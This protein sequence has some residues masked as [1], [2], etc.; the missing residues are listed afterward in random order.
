ME[1][2]KNN[3]IWPSYPRVLSEAFVDEDKELLALLQSGLEEKLHLHIRIVEFINEKP[4]IIGSF[5][6][7]SKYRMV[8]LT[9]KSLDD[10]FEDETIRTARDY[11][12]NNYSDAR[13]YI[14]YLG[15]TSF[16]YG[17]RVCGRLIAVC[18]A[19][20]FRASISAEKIKSSIQTS[21]YSGE[22][23]EEL[24]SVINTFPQF[25]DN[26]FNKM[27]VE[28]RNAVD[29]M[30][31]MATRSYR[32]RKEDSEA[33]FL[34][35]QGSFIS[36]YPAPRT[37]EELKKRVKEVLT[38]I[39]DYIGSEYVA[40]FSAREGSDIDLSL[41]AQYGLSED[42]EGNVHFNW[43]R[44]E[45][46][47]DDN[48]LDANDETRIPPRSILIKGI[49]GVKASYFD[50]AIFLQPYQF[51]DGHR[52]IMVIGPFSRDVD[53]G[54]EKGFL[55][56]TCLFVGWRTLGMVV[57]RSLEDK[58]RRRDSNI[59][60]AA[61]G[62]RSGLHSIL[63][64][65]DEIEQRTKTH[66]KTAEDEERIEQAI[67]MITSQIQTLSAQTTLIMR[68]PKETLTEIHKTELDLEKTSLAV[69]LQNCIQKYR[70]MASKIRN[71]Q[72]RVDPSIDLLPEVRVD[73]I[74]LDL[75]FSNLIDNALKYSFPGKE[76][77]IRA[78]TIN[79]SVQIYIQNYGYP[80]KPNERQK[81]FLKGYR[82]T[83]HREDQRIL[84]VGLG[85]PQSQKLIELHN[86]KIDLNCE[87]INPNDNGAVVT[88]IVT[89]PLSP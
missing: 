57:L 82:S 39:E 33:F 47:D 1:K 36:N 14:S 5:N 60:L 15:L 71:I 85:L 75:A 25:N 7:L 56:K 30:S 35:E 81:I 79:S 76:I 46:P 61:H 78:E 80:I 66:F 12:S 55:Q 20:K 54:I 53:L 27:L 77:R 11:I 83:F 43:K 88:F 22:Q 40:I 63:S 6:K 19:G 4:N 2:S 72:I 44:A 45:L 84:G 17:I 64:E 51:A 69:L 62:I 42:I 67:E 28:F 73:V 86:G 65:T 50:D 16:C 48:A 59:Q 87:N 68:S 89:L 58:D 49:R 3:F 21:P 41:T 13:A 29:I 18:I 52:G 34:E 9:A 70:G 26:D 10:M 24:I 23:K 74:L 31:R 38:K 8:C 32:N 37:G